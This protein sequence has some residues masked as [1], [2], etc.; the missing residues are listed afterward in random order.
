MISRLPRWTWTGFFLLAVNAGIVN[1]VALLCFSHSAT[2]HVTG[3]FS[4][5]SIHLHHHDY[6]SVRGI[7]LI[8]GAFFLGAFLSG[9]IIR[10][11]HFQIG[12]RYGYALAAESALLYLS[13]YNLIHHQFLGAVFASV[14]AGL[15]NAMVTNFS[16]TI[17]R[18]T[19][20]TGI[21]TDLGMYLGR[22]AAGNKLDT[23]K[24][25]LFL[26]IIAGFTGG[27]FAA[28]VFYGIFQERVMLIAAVLTT[29][30]TAGYEYFRRL[31]AGN[32]DQ[33][34]Q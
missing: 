18:T 21:V 14:A 31:P 2:T 33:K 28:S 29:A 25:G 19:H 32:T 12:R 1:V 26:L 6:Y 10:D 20:M 17:V 9:F 7:A 27:G 15:Q 30:L 24:I 3:L 13:A 11:E 34:T 4:Q 8:I 5:L 22:F 16:G 23:R